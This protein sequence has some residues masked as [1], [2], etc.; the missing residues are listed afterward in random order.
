MIK[1]SQKTDKDINDLIF[2]HM[3]KTPALTRGFV[4]KLARSRKKQILARL[5]ADPGSPVYPIRWKSE[6]QRRFVMAKL[7]REGNLPYRR[8]GAMQEAFDVKVKFT[9]RG[10]GGEVFI[11]N[12]I[13]ESVYVFGPFQQP[14]HADT[15]W[16]VIRDVIAD[17]ANAFEEDLAAAYVTLA[18]PHAGVRASQL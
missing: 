8:T 15:G 2:K 14:F 5:Q 3:N 13:P 16:P 9:K 17:E 4:N 10:K 18:D 6:K 11:V 1:A 7:R 12:P